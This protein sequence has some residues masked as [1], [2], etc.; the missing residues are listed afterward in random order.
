M[1]RIVLSL[2]VIAGLAGCSA[3]PVAYETDHERVAAIERAA[4]QAGVRVYW[5]NTPQRAVRGG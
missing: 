4:T 1:K 2:L 5:V 3:V